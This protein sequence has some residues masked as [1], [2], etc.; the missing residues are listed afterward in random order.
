M[1][2]I[3][4]VR[5]DR[6]A[7]SETAIG[8]SLSKIGNDTAFTYPF[9][10]TISETKRQAVRLFFWLFS[11]KGHMILF[12]CDDSKYLFGLY[13][14]TE[15]VIES[16][17]DTVELRLI[18]ALF[19]IWHSCAVKSGKQVSDF[20][21]FNIGNSRLN[22]ITNPPKCE[23]VEFLMDTVNESL[24]DLLKGNKTLHTTE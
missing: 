2:F 21:I 24:S 3:I 1:L 9:I 18:V 15:N 11:F 12:L 17:L 4:K 16:F 5:K 22:I 13:F 6:I 23:I 14:V 8:V 7:E 20:G 19:P 10:I